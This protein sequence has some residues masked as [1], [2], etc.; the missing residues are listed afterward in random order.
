MRKM[1]KDIRGHRLGDIYFIVPNQTYALPDEP[2]EG[3]MRDVTRSS[4]RNQEGGCSIER[5]Y[6]PMFDDS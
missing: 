1:L 3:P 4:T 5:S 2:Y 6:V